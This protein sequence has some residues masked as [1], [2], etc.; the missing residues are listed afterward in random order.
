MC[1]AKGMQ[2]PQEQ[3]NGFRDHNPLRLS[4][5]VPRPSSHSFNERL[6]FIEQLHHRSDGG[7]EAEAF[8]VFR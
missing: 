6:Q 1:G 5:L 8:N 2:N 4:S 3:I 7:V